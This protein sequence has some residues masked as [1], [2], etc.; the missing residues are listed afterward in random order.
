[1]KSFVQP[2]N[3]NEKQGAKVQYIKVANHERKAMMELFFFIAASFPQSQSL[4]YDD[5]EIQFQSRVRAVVL[6]LG[7][8]G[9]GDSTKKVESEFLLLS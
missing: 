4:G 7:A 2:R 8:G 6:S 1:M 5:T 3:P 9:R